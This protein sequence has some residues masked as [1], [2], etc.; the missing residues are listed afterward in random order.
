M[1]KLAFLFGAVVLTACL[2]TADTAPD[3]PS[4]P[5]TETFATSLGVNIPQMT[6]TAS[7]DYYKDISVGTGTLL[8][9]QLKIWVTYRGYLKTGAVFDSG[10]A[11]RFP[12]DSVIFGFHDGV[13]GMK[14]GGERLIVIPSSLGYGPY[15]VGT[16]PSNSTLVFDVHFDSLAAQ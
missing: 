8:S 2:S 5:S 15:S 16:I 10:G 4:D 1:R 13:V 7:G 6:K 9:T 12:L 3:N 14:I 11:Y